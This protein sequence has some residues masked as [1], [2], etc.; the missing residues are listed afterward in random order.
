MR[1]VAPE[2][3]PMGIPSSISP[4]DVT[5][6]KL[7]HWYFLSYGRRGTGVP[8]IKKNGRPAA[9]ADPRSSGAERGGAVDT[10]QATLGQV[11]LV[12][13]GLALVLSV[14]IL[15]LVEAHYIVRL[16]RRLGRLRPDGPDPI[17]PG[18]RAA[19]NDHAERRHDDQGIR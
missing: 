3:T 4:K 2:Y 5:N 7:A 10:I 8:P 6:L 14:I 9:A 16:S 15:L 19:E 17:G 12:L 1:R 18:S 13:I 11:L